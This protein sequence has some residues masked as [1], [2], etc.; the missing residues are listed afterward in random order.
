MRSLFAILRFILSHPLA[1]KNKGEALKR[2]FR[3]QLGKLFNPYPIVYPFT[4][5]TKLIIEKGMTGATGNIYCGLH[6]FEDMSF[7]LHFLRPEDLFVDVGANI[8]SYTVLASGHAGSKTIAIEPIPATFRRLQNNLA[9]NYLDS[10]VTAYNL[11][12]GSK[13]GVLKFTTNLDTVN[14]VAIESTEMDVIEVKVETLDQ[15]LNGLHPSLIKIDVEGFESEVLS[16]A[17]TILDDD[18]LKA[19]IIELN[20]SGGKYGFSDQDVHTFL[21]SKKFSAYKFNPFDNSLVS[22]ENYANN[23]TLYIRNINFVIERIQFSETIKIL[24]ISI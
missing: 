1:R 6:E 19:I 9:I 3:Y 14:H 21:L 12:V 11:G 2:F 24:G 4:D 5:K 7:L 8:G 22:V 18:A 13:K 23:N 15:L 16:G 17:S 20:G 10:L